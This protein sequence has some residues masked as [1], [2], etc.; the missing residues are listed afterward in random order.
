LRPDRIR[1]ELRRSPQALAEDRNEWGSN[2]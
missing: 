1:T 2:E